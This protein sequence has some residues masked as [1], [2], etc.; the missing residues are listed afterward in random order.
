MNTYQEAANI[1]TYT[2]TL[3]RDFHIHPEV[4][5][6]ELRTS[7]I[8]AQELKNLGIN[9]KPSV[10]K[11]GVVGLLEGNKKF[12]VLLLRFDMDALP[13]NEENSTEYVSQHPGIMHACGHDGHTAIGLTVAKIL[14]QHK[15]RLN[16]SVKL[17][18]QPAEELLIGARAMIEDGVLEDPKPDFAL[19]VHLWN[20]KPVG[21]FGI[22]P[23][24]IMAG[25]DRFTIRVIGSGGH[26]AN[27][28]LVNDPIIASGHILTAIQSIVSRNVP[29][30]ENAVLSVT[31]I[32]GGNSFNIIPP[33]VDLAGTIRTF[34]LNVHDLVIQ[35]LI[36]IVEGVASSF[37]CQ[38]DINIEPLT[39]PVVNDEHIA[40]VVQRTARE[41]FENVLIDSKY[42]SSVSEDMSFFM[43]NI[44]ACFLLVGSSNKF[45]KLDFPH[46][47]PRF[48]FDELSLPLA[49]GLLAKAV[50]EIINN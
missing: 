11:T 43:Q 8:V 28:H 21:W 35:R 36:S 39:M 42:I 27:P 4:G 26:G 38:V 12:P 23:G 5:F 14:N 47:H 2:Q 9:V 48:D 40:E 44:P 49:V 17:V 25:A 34:K 30:L 41:L 6:N 24:P 31:K 37:G 13:I 1:F 7:K 46:H 22:T 45:N 20:E 29:P 33:F 16:G 32:Q 50:I 3:R 18:F 10:G 15:S 19:G